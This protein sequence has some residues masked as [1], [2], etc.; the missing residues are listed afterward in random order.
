LAAGKGEGE[1]ISSV[2]EVNSNAR[3]ELRGEMGV[4]KPADVEHVSTQAQ[5]SGK[6]HVVPQSAPAELEGNGS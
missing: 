3:Y 4:E 1:Q 2:A 6:V 5:T